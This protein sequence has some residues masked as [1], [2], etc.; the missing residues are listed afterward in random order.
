MNHK[1][2]DLIYLGLFTNLYGKL[3]GVHLI[4]VYDIK[5]QIRQC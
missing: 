4:A 5:H 3:F 2:K 1:T